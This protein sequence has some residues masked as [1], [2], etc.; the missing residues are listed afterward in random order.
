MAKD[1][2]ALSY[3]KKKIIKKNKKENWLET[4]QR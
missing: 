2:K 3:E 1:C 4:A